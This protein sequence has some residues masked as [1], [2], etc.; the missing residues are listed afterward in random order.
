MAVRA[1]GIRSAFKAE[2]RVKQTALAM[3]IYFLQERKTLLDAPQQPFVYVSLAIRILLSCGHLELQGRLTMYLV[4]Q[5][6]VADAG[7]GDWDW[8]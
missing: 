1:P 5:A 4:L 8:E 2:T 7:K 3:S 6:A